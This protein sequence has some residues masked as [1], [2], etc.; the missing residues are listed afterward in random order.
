MLG[1]QIESTV[2]DARTEAFS[3]KDATV[4]DTEVVGG[5]FHHYYD[6]RSTFDRC[7]FRGT[8]FRGG[9]FGSV[10][11]P[12]PQIVYRD[13]VFDAVQIGRGVQFHDVRFERCQFR[14]G[15]IEGLISRQCEFVDCTFSGRLVDCE[16]EAT[17]TRV[18]GAVRP[19]NEFRGNDFSQADIVGGGFLFGIDLDD[20][21]LPTGDD[22][23]V[24][25]HPAAREAA[26]TRMVEAWPPSAERELALRVL[27][28]WPPTASQR[29]VLIRRCRYLASNPALGKRLLR[30]L[31]DVRLD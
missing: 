13:C 7:T 10:R 6:I 20:Q 26:V 14:R 21:V 23:L 4:A 8:K 2:L 17:T 25:D 24:L 12:E 11:P 15:R 1:A 22:Y 5:S 3:F 19:T 27:E 31:V 30:A 28:P 9:T 29:K 18:P 16:F